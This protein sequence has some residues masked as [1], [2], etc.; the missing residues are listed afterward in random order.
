MTVSGF[1]RRD[2][3]PDQARPGCRRRARTPRGPGPGRRSRAPAGR[4]RGAA[5]GRSPSRSPARP[6]APGSVSSSARDHRSAQRRAGTR[7]SVAPGQDAASSAAKP[8]SSAA[9]RRRRRVR[10]HRGDD[11]RRPGD[12][13]VVEALPAGARQVGQPRAGGGQQVRR[14]LSL[15]VA[16]AASAALADR[17]VASCDLGHQGVVDRAEQRGAG[18]GQRDEVVLAR[19][20]RGRL[21][22]C[23]GDPGG[24]RRARDG[25]GQVRPGRRPGRA[26]GGAGPRR[27][28]G[29]RRRRPQ[30]L[31]EPG[32]GALA[33]RSARIT[34]PPWSAGTTAS[35]AA[36]RWSAA[37]SR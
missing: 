30:G 23:L 7:S 32:D 4:R 16:W 6:A 37:S 17:P 18:G 10:E 33:S 21:L 11:L 1:G 28:P 27:E 3:G 12:H 26:A 13:V 14:P 9:R 5:G 35:P 15:P 25:L 19:G 36:A 22:G 31:V 24:Q 8:S 29:R 20:S 2:A 34:P